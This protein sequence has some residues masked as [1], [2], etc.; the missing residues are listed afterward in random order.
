MKKVFFSW[1]FF[2]FALIFSLIGCS[3]DEEK[4]A[5]KPVASF[6]DSTVAAIV[7][8]EAIH[9]QDIEKSAQQIGSQLGAGQDM[10]REQFQDTLRNEAFNWIVSM[11]LLGQEAAKLKIEPEQEEVDDALQAI[12]SRFPSEQHFNDALQQNNITR[13][14]F[15]ADLKN[16]LVVHK[17]LE[18]KVVKEV[19]EISDS[20]ARDFYNKNQD[21]FTKS[22]KARV[23]HILLR[24]RD[25]SNPD[26]ENEIKVRGLEIIQKLKNGGDFEDLARRYS[27]DPSAVKGGDLGEFSRGDML[28]EFEE[29]TFKLEEGKFSDLVQTKL[30]FHI[31]K[32]D[33]KVGSQKIPYEQ[34][35]AEIKQIIKQNKSNQLFEKYVLEL[36]DKADIKIRNNSADS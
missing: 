2:L 27:D 9:I 36:R 20:E 35:E 18:E 34:V 32:L 14:E 28:K 3:N 23:H 33:E 1:L 11:K 17:L 13:E 7:N 12:K 15:L 24:V 31:I 19:G 26:V 25:W 16:E 5:Q 10:Y 30:G 6:A 29:A 22:E 8:G 4:I 21:Q